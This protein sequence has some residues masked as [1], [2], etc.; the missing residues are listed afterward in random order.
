MNKSH[1]IAFAVSHCPPG[2]FINKGS[3]RCY[4]IV[5]KKVSWDQAQ[6]ECDRLGGKLAVVPDKSTWKS[7][8]DQ[9]PNK[10]IYF[11][12][13]YMLYSFNNESLYNITTNSDVIV[14]S[15]PGHS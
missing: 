9:W 15:Q 14:T 4:R 10:Y 5:E 8:A 12:N 6:E 7:L 13:F 2:S 3:R 11:L 1:V